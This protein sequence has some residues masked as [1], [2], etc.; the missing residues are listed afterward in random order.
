[1]YSMYRVGGFTCLSFSNWNERQSNRT[2][3]N[4]F[5]S[6]SKNVSLANKKL[7]VLAQ[8][9]WMQH[10]FWF[11][12]CI[13]T[14]FGSWSTSMWTFVSSRRPLKSK[15][16]P[17]NC[18]P[19]RKLIENYDLKLKKCQKQKVNGLTDDGSKS[20]KSPKM[21]TAPYLARWW[22][23]NLFR[24]GTIFAARD[25]SGPIKFCWITLNCFEMGRV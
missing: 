21:P 11:W 20:C 15:R 1:M 24:Q 8:Q 5:C 10:M 19:S 18:S 13:K 3:L 7:L 9:R 4:F 23:H 25:Q 6:C 16:R 2:F 14:Y 22:W 17:V 12:N